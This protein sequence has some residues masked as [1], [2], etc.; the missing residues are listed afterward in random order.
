M[1]VSYA[2]QRDGKQCQFCRKVFPTKWKLQR[3]ERSHTGE[4]PYSCPLCGEGCITKDTLKLHCQSKHNMTSQDYYKDV[5]PN[6]W[7]DISS[8]VLISQTPFSMTEN[9]ERICF[10]CRLSKS[11]T[12]RSVHTVQASG[13]I[14][15]NT[16]DKSMVTTGLTPVNFAARTSSEKL[17][18][19]DTPSHNIFPSYLKIG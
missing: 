3:H 12:V 5:Y 2:E 11:S 15:T 8:Q 19:T 10:F 9:V 6:L 1:A 4:R 16:F 7:N 18:W 13:L 14:S 17:I